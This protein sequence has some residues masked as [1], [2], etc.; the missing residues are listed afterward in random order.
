MTTDP[1][2][3]VG[4]AASY[5]GMG[6]GFVYRHSAALG[7]RKVGSRLKFKS[8]DLDAYLD[9]VQVTEAAAY[10]PIPI[11]TP[12][13]PLRLKT[14]P[15]GKVTGHVYTTTPPPLAERLGGRR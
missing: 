10:E 14:S 3:D 2:L 15:A 7:G 8:A 1:L 13:A 11:S 9:T 5:L 6:R 4:Q 12:R